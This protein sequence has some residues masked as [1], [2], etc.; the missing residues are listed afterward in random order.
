[1]NI[2]FINFN[3]GATVGINNGIA[4]MS[5]CL[6]R[7]GHAVLL[8]HICDALDYPF[9]L[10]RMKQ[11]IQ[12]F[13]PDVVGLSLMEPQFKYAVRFC[14]DLRRYYDGFVF[15]G[16]PFPTMDPDSAID[17]PGVNAV[18]VGEGEEAVCELVDA[19]GE[20]ADVSGIRNL[21]VRQPDGSVRKNLLRPFIDLATLPPDDKALFDLDRI[22]PLKNY[23]LETM[24]GRGCVHKC[25]YCIND[26][27]LG[28]YRDHCCAPATMKQYIRMKDIDVA[29]DE[30]KAVIA[31]H[32]EI[33]KIAFVDDNILMYPGRIDVFLERYKR[34]IG[35]PFV[36]NTSPMVFTELKGR[37]LQDAGCD[38]IRFGIE[39]GSERV[40]REI[41]NRSITNE[42]V[43]RAFE[44]TRKLGLMSSSY[45]MIGLPTETREEVMETLCLNARIQPDSV[46]LMTFYPF[47]NTP[48]YDLCSDMNL[49]DEE[50]KDLLDDYDTFTCLKFEPA[51]QFFLEK[52]Q[53]AFNWYINMFMNTDASAIYAERAR[54][55]E[56]MDRGAWRAFDFAAADKRLSERFQS[57]GVPHYRKFVNRSLAA[58]YPSRHFGGA[59]DAETEN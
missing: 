20:G 9:D 14:E 37:S 10:A 49:I 25:T 38:D 23:Q 33:R 21:W 51:H 46:K 11:D 58:R 52:V 47:K 30:I 53:V 40:K 45:N 41:M 26:S 57:K 36:C 29:L 31:T 4:A 7:D 13:S 8:L 6:K 15:C 43:V 56:S 50:K 54:E 19:L 35:L 42:S 44:I 27:Y 16:G 34:E 17:A 12:A 5:A 1:V 18:C 24:I 3:I 22:L 2:L 59:E 28:I 39:S 55:L 32:P 48:I